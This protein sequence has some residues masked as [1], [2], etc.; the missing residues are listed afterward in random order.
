MNTTKAETQQPTVDQAPEA[1][2]TVSAFHAGYERRLYLGSQTLWPSMRSLITCSD[3]PT[4]MSARAAAW[5]S[6]RA[7]LDD[8]LSDIRT[9]TYHYP[10]GAR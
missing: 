4:P 1:T 5:I 6:R 3:H 7:E 9:E 10:G 8:D 2:Y